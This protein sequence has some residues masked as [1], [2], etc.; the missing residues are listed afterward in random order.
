MS[1]FVPRR[2]R[3]RK[4]GREGITDDALS[5]LDYFL[6]WEPLHELSLIHI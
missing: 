4:R 3:I 5:M 2:G 1:A 6:D